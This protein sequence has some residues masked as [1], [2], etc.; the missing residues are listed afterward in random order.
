MAVSLWDSSASRQN[1]PDASRFRKAEQGQ[2]T[3]SCIDAGDDGIGQPLR[4][5]YGDIG[6]S[7]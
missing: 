6:Q 5:E 4:R 7:D 3:L 1:Q 2:N